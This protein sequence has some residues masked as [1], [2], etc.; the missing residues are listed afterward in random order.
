MLQPFCTIM[1]T[2]LILMGAGSLALALK[3]LDFRLPVRDLTVERYESCF[4]G[5]LHGHNLSFG[6]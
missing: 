1:N 3:A 6:Q 4:V 5:R 2:A